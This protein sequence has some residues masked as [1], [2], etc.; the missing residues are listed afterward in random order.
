MLSSTGMGL[1]GL[2]LLTIG[3]LSVNGAF[4]VL[5]YPCRLCPTVPCRSRSPSRS[6]CSLMTVE[7]HYAQS[8]WPG[9]SVQ[10]N[11]T[12]IAWLTGV[13]KLSATKRALAFNCNESAQ[14]FSISF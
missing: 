8:N 9:V 13:K 5:P 3:L 11:Q 2:D 12:G 1:L 10:A 7:T 6:V 4:S 14:P